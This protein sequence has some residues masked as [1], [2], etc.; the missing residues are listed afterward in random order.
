MKLGSN[1][2]GIKLIKAKIFKAANFKTVTEITPCG[3]K[4]H[5]AQNPVVRIRTTFFKKLPNVGP[6]AIKFYS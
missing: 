3:L 5:L 2:Y 1:A 6:N 4:A